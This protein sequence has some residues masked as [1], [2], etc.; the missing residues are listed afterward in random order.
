MA[1]KARC[2]PLLT[3][4]ASGLEIAT[5][6]RLSGFGLNAKLAAGGTGAEARK[7]IAPAPVTEM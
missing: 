5:E 1:V 3:G 6:A 7:G 4:L 2:A